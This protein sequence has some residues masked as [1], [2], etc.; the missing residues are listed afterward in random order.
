M[1]INQL[2][3]HLK[4][5]KSAAGLFVTIYSPDVVE[6]A[7]LSGYDFVIIDNEHGPGTQETAVNL[8][9]AAEN[10][11]ITPIV[12]IP[13]QFESTILHI[14][15]IGAHGIQVPQVNDAAAARAIISRAKYYP[16]GSRGV[17]MPRSTDYGLANLNEY[18][19]QENRET[20]V[21]VHCENKMGLDNLD[22]ICQ[23]P[24][25]DVIFLGPYD[26]SQSLGIPGQVNHELVEDAARQVLAAT[27]KYHKI[28][29]VY[30]GSAETA[31]LRERQ[32][33]QYLGFGM[34]TTMLA[35][36][37]KRAIDGWKNGI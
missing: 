31:R 8:I 6:I 3:K 15:D 20:L 34:D 17:A 25:I 37:C 16:E 26:M 18:F 14:L 32:G 5:G 24:G 23:V 27:R 36:G 10:R 12:R 1:F 22:E 9:R 21:V 4:A 35:S 29:G 13:N 7:A 11:G 28:P 2:K 30:V 19:I 33:F